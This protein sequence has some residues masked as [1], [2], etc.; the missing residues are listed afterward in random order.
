MLRTGLLQ[1]TQCCVN[2]PG[3]RYTQTQR[4]KRRGTEH[5]L[6][7]IIPP[8]TQNST[9]IPHWEFTKGTAQN[10]RIQCQSLTQVWQHGHLQPLGKVDSGLVELQQLGQLG[11]L[12][13]PL[14]GS[15]EAHRDGR[16]QSSQGLNQQH[17][18]DFMGVLENLQQQNSY[19]Q[20]HITR[21]EHT[22]Q[23]RAAGSFQT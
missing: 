2:S 5:C 3:G 12:A 22:Q 18:H 23:Q 20:K 15:A 9:K 19:W 1:E 16:H 14:H 17:S 10:D 4:G 7:Q 21:E 8:S 6:E 13:R 11:V